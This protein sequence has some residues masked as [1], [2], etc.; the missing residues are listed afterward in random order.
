MN[1]VNSNF[2]TSSFRHFAAALSAPGGKTVAGNEGRGEDSVVSIIRDKLTL[3]SE[4]R[5]AYVAYTNKL[6]KTEQNAPATQ[7]QDESTEPFISDDSSDAGDKFF[8]EVIAEVLAA[9]APTPTIIAAEGLGTLEKVENVQ[10]LQTEQSVELANALQTLARAE[11]LWETMRTNNPSNGIPIELAP[12]LRALGI[13]GGNNTTTTG[14]AALR[15][16]LQANTEKIDDKISGI[17]KANGI[18]LGKNETLNLKV[19]Q[20]G[21]ITVGDGV[22]ADKRKKLETLLNE[23][24]TLARDLLF[25]HDERKSA[26]SGSGLPQLGT[27]DATYYTAIDAVLQREYGVSLADFQL[28]KALTGSNAET[29]KF[30]QS[31]SI[32]FGNSSD[33]ILIGDHALLDKLFSE[34][35][36]LYEGIQKALTLKEERGDD[37]GV[38]FI[39]K[40]G[41]TI[42]KGAAD[43]KALNKFSERFAPF[44]FPDFGVKTAVTIDPSGKILNA[45]V[46]DMGAGAQFFGNHT[47]ATRQLNEFFKTMEAVP[48]DFGLPSQSRLQQYA[49]DAQRLFQ[50]NTGIDA[51]TAKSMNVSFGTSGARSSNDWWDT[52]EPAVKENQASEWEEIDQHVPTAPPAQTLSANAPTPT[53]IAA[54]GLDSLQKVENIQF[55]QPEQLDELTAFIAKISR[56]E[57]LLGLMRKNMAPAEQEFRQ[58]EFSQI[59]HFSQAAS[60]LKQSNS[61]GN[62]QRHGFSVVHAP[63]FRALGIE[64]VRMPV[65][66]L[67]TATANK[68][69]RAQ[70]QADLEK[71]DGKISDI[72]K[73]NGIVLGKNETL[74]LRVSQLGKITVGDGVS[75]DK[76]KKLETL[77]NE[78][79]TLARDLLFAH[80]A[81]QLFAPGGVQPQLGTK[82][83]YA[84]AIDTIL[85]QEYGVSLDDFQISQSSMNH[86]NIGQRRFLHS[87]VPKG[88]DSNV[89]FLG[90][91]DLL[92]KLFSEDHPLYQGIIMALEFVE[93]HG[94]DLGVDFVYK[95]GITIEKGA[96]DQKALNKISE[97]F[98]HGAFSDFGMKTSMT[99]DFSGRILNAQVTDIGGGGKWFS[100]I[101]HATSELKEF[102]KRVEE[103]AFD[104][105]LPSQSRL[106]Q[107]VFDSQ[108]LFQ[109][110]TGVDTETA[111]S[112]NVAF[113]TS[114]T[115]WWQLDKENAIENANESVT[116]ENQVSELAEIDQN[117]PVAPVV[118][119]PRIFSTAPGSVENLMRFFGLNTINGNDATLAG[120][121]NLTL[122]TEKQE[123]T[124]ML[125]D[126]LQKA[127]MSNEKN[128]IIIAEDDEGNIVIEG[129]IDAEKKRLLAELINSDPELVERIKDHKAK[130]EIARGLDPEGNLDIS[131]DQFAAA[132]NQLLKSFL[133]REG[134]F[135]L[136]DIGFRTDP[137]SEMRRLIQQDGDGNEIT[138]SLL[139]TLLSQMPGLET[140]L[141][142][143][144]DSPILQPQGQRG[145]TVPLL[146]I[147]NGA[148]SWGTKEKEIVQESHEP[149]A[150]AKGVEGLGKMENLPLQQSEEQAIQEQMRLAIEDFHLKELQQRGAFTHSS[151]YSFREQVYEKSKHFDTLGWALGLQMNNS[152]NDRWNPS[153]NGD[154]LI[155]GLPAPK[156]SAMS[157]AV[158]RSVQTK[159]NVLMLRANNQANWEKIDKKITDVLK[160]NDIVLEEKEKLTFKVNQRGEITLGN[161]VNGSKREK[162]E[163]LLNEDKTLAKDLLYAHAERRWA[164]NDG[165]GEGYEG[166]ANV[167]R[168]I[169]TDMVLQREYGVSLNDIQMS[170]G[171]HAGLLEKLYNEERMFYNDIE[172]ALKSLEENG[173]DFEV[174][175]AYKNNITIEPGV[176]DQ[177]AMDIMG[178]RLFSSWSWNPAWG[179]ETSVTLDPTGRILNAQVTGLGILSSVYPVHATLNAPTDQAF[180]LNHLNKELIT[181]LAWKSDCNSAFI[182]SQSR[183]Q[184]FA[185]DSQR[186]FQF[187]TGADA[188]IAKAMNV[189]FNTSGADWG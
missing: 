149:H 78:D 51:E 159:N 75:A 29:W 163:K 45:Q 83:A 131:S 1:S 160:S 39:Y 2:S 86:A 148:V 145:E 77:L 62:P 20:L 17:L 93:E 60:F 176:T 156:W 125:N 92:D 114:G 143:F 82:A 89:L 87:L 58:D 139:P 171:D 187:N 179:V 61:Q 95:N 18:I 138:D 174:R 151:K 71:I 102:F 5:S 112:M 107:Y 68:T 183:L 23:D 120:A 178:G 162:I 76:Q 42:E 122:E 98:T 173:G 96:A 100:N 16:Q 106:Q 30:G 135:S 72:L 15:A 136:T 108:R 81:R 170:G 177:P 165:G 44:F 119:A 121:L 152:W 67:A 124:D 73:A 25:I 109:F 137:V 79:K 66:A 41:V 88:D 94:D 188:D 31:H 182:P 104:T 175:F 59:P 8:N 32:V 115:P 50:F 181:H 52:N 22:S 128:E 91:H 28:S 158:Y 147:N 46:T 33:E 134:G 74:N 164:V 64:E 56:A 157:A 36:A 80:D 189:T 144:L 21:K 97:R 101:A 55:Y 184:Q 150:I 14:V 110:N 154:Y 11:K 35:F 43:Q 69:F 103:V 9:N 180:I 117:V 99:L 70:L 168:Y 169:L 4:G 49:F 123:L 130:R 146:K 24:K 126:L 38:D 186:L 12:R 118:E 167:E 53:V 34:D 10:L 19:S 111:K 54:E 84:T 48:F 57:E 65:A 90:E 127:G 113:S 40:N 85:R 129:D 185:F 63:R 26:G 172:N 13:G 133:Q 37:L 27:S 166:R 142:R 105:W 153:W 161:G 47:E 155:N 7:T 6:N 116:A 132:R 140:E 141:F 3:S